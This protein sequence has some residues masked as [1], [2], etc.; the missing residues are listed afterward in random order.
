M[1][2]PEDFDFYCDVALKP[3]ANIKIE[4]E[5]DRVLAFHH[6]KPNWPVHIVVIPKNHI[7]DIRF[8][9]DPTLLA[10]LLSVA[11]DILKSFSQEFLDE[12]GA[13]IIT[14]L[15]KYQDT[16][17]LHFHVVCGKSK[18]VHE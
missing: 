13:R 5:T 10:E 11:K 6:T 12:Q 2:R 9:D 4:Q 15:G 7:W 14:N 18:V 3:G 16:P 8:V 17:H 1:S